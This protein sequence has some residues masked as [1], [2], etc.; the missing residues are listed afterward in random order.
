MRVVVGI[1]ITFFLGLLVVVWYG[2]ERANPQIIDV[3]PVTRSSQ[4]AAEAQPDASLERRIRTGGRGG[5]HRDGRALAVS[6]PPSA[7]LERGEQAPPEPPRKSSLV[8]KIFAGRD[9]SAK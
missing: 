7:G 5:L 9:G 8:R 2:S 6:G 4:S 3:D 1:T